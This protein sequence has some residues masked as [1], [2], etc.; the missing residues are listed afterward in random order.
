[1]RRNI[2]LLCREGGVGSDIGVLEVSISP[3]LFRG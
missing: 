1:M 3:G 2:Y